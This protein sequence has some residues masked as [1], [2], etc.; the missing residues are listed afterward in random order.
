[1]K[2][3]ENEHKII[4]TEKITRVEVIDSKGRSYVNWEN[5]NIVELCLQDDCRTLKI[6]I[7]NKDRNE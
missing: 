4:S 1:M 3:K 2:G 6:F 5:N 7:Y